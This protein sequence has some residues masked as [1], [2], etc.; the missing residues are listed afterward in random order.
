MQPNI[1][2]PS[3]ALDSCQRAKITRAIIIQPRPPN[4]P[5]TH[6]F[7]ATTIKYPPAKP[8]KNVPIMTENKWPTKLR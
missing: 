3:K 5:S 7:E 4:I 8:K 6:I 2:A 1:T